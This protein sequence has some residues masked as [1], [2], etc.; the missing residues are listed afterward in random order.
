M[1]NARGL[2]SEKDDDD[3]NDEQDGNRGRKRRAPLPLPSRAI[4]GD[5]PEGKPANAR[6]AALDEALANLAIRRREQEEASRRAQRPDALPEESTA[7][8]PELPGAES[9]YAQDESEVAVNDPEIDELLPGYD[10]EPVEFSGGEVIIHLDGSVPVTEREIPLRAER[11]SE[12]GPVTNAEVPPFVPP[13]EWRSQVHDVAEE[14]E[15]TAASTVDNGEAPPPVYPPERPV[16][17]FE[18]P[19]QPFVPGGARPV[20]VLPSE[21]EPAEAYRAYQLRRQNIP[22]RPATKRQV[23]H[24]VHDAAK[25][26]ER[27]GRLEGLL[28]GG[29]YEH[30]KHKRRERLAE[31]RAKTQSKQLENARKDYGSVRHEQEK[32]RNDANTLQQTT[33]QRLKDTERRARLAEEAAM[34]AQAQLS[35]APEHRLQTSAWHTIEVDAKTGKAVENPTFRYGH[36]YHQERAQ[37]S[38]AVNSRTMAAGGVAVAGASSNNA[39]APDGNNSLPPVYIPSATTQGPP[40]NTPGRSQKPADTSSQPSTSAPLWPWVIA[41]LVIA[42]CLTV[43]LH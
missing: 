2:S 8:E 23:E 41:L 5:Q 15:D 28:V 43:A 29:V 10:P 4:I 31:K 20:E 11:A 42:V 19:P 12:E 27:Q 34:A 26:G 16:A 35:V 13:A 9:E 21:Q 38:G 17:S 6:S 37:E 33:E 18:Q 32:Q 30:Y 39:T 14:P 22:D 40:Q 36:E 3:E 7:D 1:E 24:A 25:A